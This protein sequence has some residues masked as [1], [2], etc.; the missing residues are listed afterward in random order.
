MNFLKINLVTS[1][2]IPKNI[3]APNNEARMPLSIC[4]EIKI[5]KLLFNT[6]L[7]FVIKNTKII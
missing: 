1:S 3:N 6:L 5:E 2:A 7:L 4:T